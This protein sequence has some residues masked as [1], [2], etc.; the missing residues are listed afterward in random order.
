MPNPR[1]VSMAGVQALTFVGMMLLGVGPAW[2]QMVDEANVNA[3]DPFAAYHSFLSRA[4]ER[5]LSAPAQTPMVQSRA[6]GATT[7]LV[8]PSPAIIKGDSP[9]AAISRVQRLRPVIEPIL[10]QERVPPE[11]TAIVLV[12]SGGQ[13]NAL[14]PKGARGI[15]Q[16]MPDTARRYGLTVTPARD[17]R[18]DIERSTRAAAR[19]LRDLHTQFGDWQ[20]AIAAYNAGGDLV[21][22]AIECNGTRDFFKL[23]SRSIPLE[24]KKYVPAVFNAIK[25]IGK[26]NAAMSLAEE[27]ATSWKVFAV[28][29]LTN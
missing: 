21:Q 8:S 2:S 26:P 3:T 6:P 20:L 1:L 5:A 7:A 12:E 10:R 18:L 16:F 9:A 14:S 24:T 19:Y 4:A 22:H 23:S 25:V 17:E 27:S 28:A 11:L 13:I 29:Q 15:W